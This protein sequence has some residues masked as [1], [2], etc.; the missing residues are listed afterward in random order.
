[1]NSLSHTNYSINVGVLQTAHSIFRPWRAATR[2]D[3]LFAVINNVLERFCKPF[4]HLFVHTAELLFTNVPGDA[5]STM[6]LRAQAMVLLVEIF[7]DLT[8]QDLPPDIEDAHAQFF[9]PDSG[10]FL[11]FLTW[12]PPE[13]QGEVRTNLLILSVAL[14]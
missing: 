11:R 7:Y 5:T 14:Y 12:D 8:C 4:L 1:M 9:G 13:M 2:S 10:L 6:E 3:A